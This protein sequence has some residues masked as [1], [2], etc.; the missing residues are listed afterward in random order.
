LALDGLSVGYVTVYDR[1][2]ALTNAEKQRR[3]RDKRNAMADA[4]AGTPEEVAEGVLRLLGVEKATRVTRALDKRLRR[5]KSDCPSCH[6]SG[7]LHLEVTTSCGSST[8][9]SPI[10][11][12]SCDGALDWL[13]LGAVQL[14]RGRRVQ[15]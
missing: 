10:V 11:A 9:L 4:V 5:L 1:I 3:W 14:T 6:G 8:G 7:F 12:C 15:G 2:M 13:T